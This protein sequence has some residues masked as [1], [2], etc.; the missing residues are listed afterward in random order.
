[1]P[2]DELLSMGE[3]MTEEVQ[4][5]TRR[6]F[7]TLA[8]AGAFGANIPSLGGLAEGAQKMSDVDKKNVDAVLGMSAAFKLRDASKLAPFFHDQIAFRGGADNMAAPPTVGKDKVV[9]SLEGFMKTT[10]ID[11]RV[12]DAFALDP[13]VV[14]VHHQ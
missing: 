8:G 2:H 5:V 4:A 1:M 13:V 6:L 14:T 12:L 10:S 9:S 11:M 7:M 3:S